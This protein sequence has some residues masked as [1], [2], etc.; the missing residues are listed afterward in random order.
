MRALKG[1]TL[2][3]LLV[4]IVIIGIL[5]TGIM[6]SSGTAVSTARVLA[7]INDLRGLKEAA[8]LLYLDSPD[9]APS[10]AALKNYIANPEKLT[11]SDYEIE[12]DGDRYFIGYKLKNE[13]DLADV[14]S[15]LAA[16]AK[17]A[18]LLNATDTSQVYV[19][20]ET[21]YVTAY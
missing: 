5:S 21:V 20:G 16:R 17:S 8:L 2:I 9:E 15:R 19:N 4:V 14:K 3:E 6:I 18:G 1:F 7:I 11:D 10:I 13:P 12:K